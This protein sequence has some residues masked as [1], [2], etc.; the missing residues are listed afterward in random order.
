MVS[1]QEIKERTS[2]FIREIVEPVNLQE[3]NTLPVSAFEPG[4]RV[5]VG[6][7]ASEKRGIALKVPRVDMDKCTQC[8]YCSLICPH[9]AVR[10]FLFTHDEVEAAPP[11]VKSATKPAIGG[12][13]LD[14]YQYR[15]QVGVCVRACACVY[16][17]ICISMYV[18]VY[19]YVYIY[20]YIYGTKNATKPGMGGSVLDQ[21]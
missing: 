21:H 20:I 10:P 3:G 19:I 15:I 1:A 11:G 5:A 18:C 13:V 14:Q 12:G 9:A 17:C 4:G 16:R 8:N 7:S 2:A 6:T